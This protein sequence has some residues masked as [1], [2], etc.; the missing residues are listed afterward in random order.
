[1]ISKYKIVVIVVITVV[2]CVDIVGYVRRELL[3]NTCAVNLFSII[4][5]YCTVKHYS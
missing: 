3:S 4:T 5:E 2:W 1:M